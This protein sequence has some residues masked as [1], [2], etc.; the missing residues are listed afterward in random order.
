M[1]LAGRWSL[2]KV[3]I[4]GGKMKLGEEV[5]WVN[6]GYG[7]SKY[8]DLL[9]ILVNFLHSTAQRLWTSLKIH[10]IVDCNNNYIIYEM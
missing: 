10:P 4:R 9:Y 2:G 3:N 5:C 8:E 7:Y 6:W 1:K